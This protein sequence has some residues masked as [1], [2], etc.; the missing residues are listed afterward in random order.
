MLIIASVGK[1]K[2]VSIISNEEAIKFLKKNKTKDD[3]VFVR[4]S[5]IWYAFKNKDNI[6]G[7]I[8][9]RIKDKYIK[10]DTSFTLKNYRKQGISTLLR[11]YIIQKFNNKII[12]SYSNKMSQNINKKLGFKVIRVLKNGTELLRYNR[13]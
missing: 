9:I 4:Y 12:I 8:G 6:M 13:S 7:I 10:I 11:K 2:M 5:D 1:L 3:Y